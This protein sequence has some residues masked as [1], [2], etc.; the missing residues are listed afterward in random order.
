[1]T[2]ADLRATLP[3]QAPASSGR[4]QREQRLFRIAQ[5]R[6]FY[7]TVG[8]IGAFLHGA[9][10]LDAF[11]FASRLLAIALLVIFLY[12]AYQF[13]RNGAKVVPLVPIIVLQFYIMYGFAQ[14]S[15]SEM[16]V[17]DGIYV[18]PP[19]AVLGAM[20]FAVTASLVFL[21]GARAGSFISTATNLKIWRRFPEPTTA[22]TPFVVI[23]AFVSTTIRGIEA[24]WPN[25][26]DV[27]FRNVVHVLLN[28]NLGFI[29]LLYVYMRLRVSSVRVLVTVDFI[30]LVLTGLLTAALEPII[31]PVFLY[32]AAA[33]IWLRKIRVRWAVAGF[34]VYMLL[35]PAKMS[36][37]QWVYQEN[38]TG[39]TFTL[40]SAA[41]AWGDAIAS[42]WSG[43]GAAQRAWEIGSTRAS[44]LMA[45]AQGVDWIP[46]IVPY[47]EGE[48]FGT[49]LLYFIPRLFWPDKPG[50]S[51]LINNKYALQFGISTWQGIQVST[52][53]V[54]QPFDGYWHFGFPGV[55]AFSFV[56]GG[57]IGLLWL[58]VEKASAT[59]VVLGF[60]FTA[61]FFQSLGPLQTILASILSLLSGTWVVFLVFSALGKA[62]VAAARRDL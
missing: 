12:A 19:D 36:Y 58:G 44:A 1:M 16:N 39:A 22:W 34:L 29:L 54:I 26:F 15:Q 52:F 21:I 47:A 13:M 3:Y 62:R 11:N 33:G 24:V 4:M 57:V 35:G 31:V 5:N 25:T 43:E 61:S 51:D 30:F 53:G 37:R 18:P 17:F 10:A 49:S 9:F 2:A 48:G 6:R 20:L 40:E 42:G 56:F 8:I 23:Y 59:G 60:L 45:L 41:V 46:S 38:L 27:E 7:I 50:I 55:V 14:F 32:F 28:A